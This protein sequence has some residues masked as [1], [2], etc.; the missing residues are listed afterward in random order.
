MSDE[1]IWKVIPG[2]S[3]YEASNLGRIRRLSDGFVIKPLLSGIPQYY[4]VNATPDGGKNNIRR[5]HILVAKAFIDNPDNLPVVDHINRDPLDNRIEN[6][7]WVTRKGNQRNKHN[8]FYVDYQGETKLLVEVIEELFGEQNDSL[9]YQFLAGRIR[10]KYETIEEALSEYGRYVEVGEKLKKV[11]Y[12]GETVFLKTLCDQKGYDYKQSCNRLNQGW[13]DWNVAYNIN[14]NLRGQE[15]TFGNVNLWFPNEISAENYFS[16]GSGTLKR[17]CNINYDFVN[18]G[19]YDKHEGNRDRVRQEVMG[20]RG[21]VA[22]LADHFG[23]TVSCVQARVHKGMTLEEALSKPIERLKYVTIDGERK[24]LKAW[25][26]HFQLP[27]GRVRKW[28]DNHKGASFTQTLKNFGVDVSN[29]KI[30]EG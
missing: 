2:Y 9:I 16:I 5:V 6:L 11:E 15:L 8:N 14:P 23:K 13:S 4:Y 7:R 21:T 26:A 10:T 27:D 20:V 19:S 3:R 17:L 1:E 22:E 24:T 25:Y 18:I 30:L 12:K 29:L 28:R